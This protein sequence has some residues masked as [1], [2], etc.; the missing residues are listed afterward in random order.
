MKKYLDKTGLQEFT[1]K[2]TA[3]FKTV[4]ALKGETATDAQV[5]EAVTD[6]LDTNVNPVGSAVVVDSTLSVTGAAAD[7]KKTGDEISNLKNVII[8]KVWDIGSY[9]RFDASLVTSGKIIAKNGTISSSANWSLS[10]YIPVNPGMILYAAYYS[11][12]SYALFDLNKNLVSSPSTPNWT[13]PY[14]V[15]T[16]VYY[17]RMSIQTAYLSSAYVSTKNE[18]DEYKTLLPYV[19]D[20]RDNIESLNK[21]NENL[22]KLI[23]EETVPLELI[24]HD[25]MIQG[26]YVENNSIGSPNTITTRAVYG[27]AIALS[28]LDDTVFAFNSNSEYNMS[29][30]GFND[31]GV[32]VSTPGS[33]LSDGE[34]TKAQIIANAN[35]P[36]SANYFSF[37]IRKTNNTTVTPGYADSIASI[38]VQ[39]K[40][41]VDVIMFMGQ[42]NMAGRGTAADSPIL[43]PR[44]GFEYKAISAP[45]KLSPM[46]EPFGVAENNPNGINDGTSKTGD[47]V[48]AFTNAYY[49]HN[50]NYSVVGI[51]ASRGGTTIAEWQPNGAYLNDAISRLT[52]CVSFL[53]SNGYTIRHKYVLWCQ[54]E[55]DGDSNTSA[56]NYKAAL[57]TMFNELAANGIEKMF[58]VRIGYYNSG[59]STK[60]NTIIE[61]QTE[62]T[63]T[64]AN[65]IMASTDFTSMKD[66][67]LMKDLFH[68]YQAAYNEV[69][70]YSGINVAIYEQTEKEPTM[71]DPHDSSLYYSHK[72]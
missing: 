66:R 31:S 8:D 2:L 38:V 46:E 15:P 37:Q 36:N 4:F 17:I 44:A 41:T 70:E 39:Q 11:A 64:E 40:S 24:Q 27:R 29:F 20:S 58:L 1:T 61:C 60:Y 9:N 13:N 16:G 67:G 47:M 71:Y 65:I 63:Q 6:W 7:A 42:S 35:I 52:S 72:N 14:T 19:H 53:T 33:W 68:Y 32:C 43:I 21:A 22:I 55:S 54:G 18:Y 48:V 23:D 10:D 45:N 50:G 34:Y 57:K 26:Q 28:E 5:A 25:L 59:S 3:K 30:L 12:S 56:S 49:S 69:G 51:S 62:I